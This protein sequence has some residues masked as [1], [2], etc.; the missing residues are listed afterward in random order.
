MLDPAL[1]ESAPSVQRP[2]SNRPAATAVPVEE[3]LGAALRPAGGSCYRFLA[4]I[5]LV[6]GYSWVLLVVL[7]FGAVAEGEDGGEDAGS[8]WPSRCLRDSKCSAKVVHSGC[9]SLPESPREVT[10]KSAVHRIHS[11]E[12]P[13]PVCPPK[14]RAKIPRDCRRWCIWVYP[15][16]LCFSGGLLCL[17]QVSTR[18]L[19]WSPAATDLLI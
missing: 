5:D 10:E 6:L 19:I 2:C 4:E 14:H 16:C 12:N 7:W 1:W 3:H 15:R 18:E 9:N 8:S 11:A 13:L 17:S